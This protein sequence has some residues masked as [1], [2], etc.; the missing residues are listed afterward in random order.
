MNLNPHIE[1]PHSHKSADI[2]RPPLP[3]LLD[4]NEAA[5]LVQCSPNYMRLSRH[6]GQLFGVPAPAFL[7]M[8]R[9]VRYRRETLLSWLAQFDEKPNTAAC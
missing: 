5:E 7:K 2:S 8:G 3:D 6:T 9:K 1:R 4:N